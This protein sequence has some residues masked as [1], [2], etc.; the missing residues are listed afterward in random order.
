MKVSKIELKGVKSFDEKTSITFSDSTSMF[1]FSGKNG[2]GKSTVLKAMW[3]IQKAYFVKLINNE[4]VTKTFTHEMGKLLNKKDSYIVL[5]FISENNPIVIK[6]SKNN[7]SDTGYSLECTNDEALRKHW[8]LISPNNLILYID[9]SKGFSEKTLT[10]DELNIKGNEKGNLVLEAI[11]NPEGLFSGIYRQ[12]IKDYI[13]DRLIPNKPDRLLYYHISSK[14]FTNLIPTVELKN[15]SGNHTPG[16][17]VL[18]GKSAGNRASYIYDVRDF[19]SGE[20]ALLSTLTF[21]CI[22]KTVSTLIIDEPENHF[23]ESLLLEFMSVLKKL[24]EKGG[25]HKWMEEVTDKG[26]KVK[27]EWVAKEYEDHY[28]KQ[29]IIST[30]S[31]SLIYKFFLIGENYIVNNTITRILYDDAESELRNLGLSSVYSKVLL[32]EGDSD[33]E[34]LELALQDKSLQIK[35]LNGS[36]AVIDTFKRLSQ[37]KNHLHDS[38]FVFL[39]DSDNKP[40]EFFE[41]LKEIDSQYFSDSFIVMDRHEFENYFLDANLIKLTID[42][43][44]DV[45]GE[46]FRTLSKDDIE[47]KLIEIARESLPTVY[48]KELSLVFQQVVERKFA[49]LIWGNSNFKWNDKLEIKDNLEQDVLTNQEFIKLKEELIEASN[50]VFTNYSLISNADL[51]KRCDGKQVL[52]KSA[53]YFSNASNFKSHAFKSALYKTA[54][55][56]PS[57][58]ASKLIKDILAKFYPLAEKDVDSFL[59]D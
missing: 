53:G 16:E 43:L 17:F 48:K 58:D 5:E 7:E 22:T 30:H 9:A 33:H 57:S 42:K 3:I 32:V 50:D 4:E 6:L 40:S 8:N 36:S 56:L 12:L 24:C 29:V 35:P 54:F 21:L 49:S 18:L 34:A 2:A 46:N 52:S 14:L 59:A 44:L 26:K 13:H 11:L 55:S 51:L 45:T 23:H 10:F 37:L 19:S 39:V 38:T 20:K 47:K 31:K 25:I 28:I 41:K 1:A 15:F 27:L